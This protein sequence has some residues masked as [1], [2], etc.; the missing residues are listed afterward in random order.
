MFITLN[1][2]AE[3]PNL[4]CYDI[5]NS[6]NQDYYVNNKGNCFCIIRIT[7]SELVKTEPDFIQDTNS[8]DFSN[9][10]INNEVNIEN[11]I[12][13]DMIYGDYND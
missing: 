5:C 7:D 3:N 2:F 13:I 8:I 10:E 4:Y 9:T 11:N 6:R 1:C 12:N